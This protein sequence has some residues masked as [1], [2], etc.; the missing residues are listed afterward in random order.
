MNEISSKKIEGYKN[1]YGLNNFSIK[2]EQCYFYKYIPID[3]FIQSVESNEL[4]FVSPTTW[5]DP[6]ER[7]YF[8]ADCSKHNYSPVDMACMC[9]T[10]EKTKNEEAAWKIYSINGTKSVRVSFKISVLFSF[11]DKYAT[12]NQCKVYIGYVNYELNKTDINNIYK[13]KS[14]YHS[15]FC[16]QNMTTDH[17]LSLMLL[18]RKSFEYE[19]EI[20]IFIVSED[21]IKFDENRK[22]LKLPCIYSKTDFLS[23]ITLSP[24]PTIKRSTIKGKIYSKLNEIESKELKKQLKSLLG[25]NCNI[26]QS[27]LYDDKK[28]CSIE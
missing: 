3:R 28:T 5:Y 26:Q 2:K 21:K 24:Y 10:S 20:R 23:D 4:V 16:P 11:L 18:K 15:I 9:V 8:N 27:R 12:D 25:K 19:N 7:L 1:I 13:K 22:L 14:K 17:Y 6:F